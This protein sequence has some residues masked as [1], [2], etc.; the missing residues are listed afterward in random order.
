MQLGTV[1]Y[2]IY[3]VRLSVFKYNV[4]CTVSY[5]LTA[6]PFEAMV[7]QLTFTNA[8][9]KGGTFKNFIILKYCIEL[10]FVISEHLQ[11]YIQCFFFLLK[12]KVCF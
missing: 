11:T 5:S 6:K 10:N 4:F 12:K 8:M 2:R 7:Y 3:R 9:L 1:Q